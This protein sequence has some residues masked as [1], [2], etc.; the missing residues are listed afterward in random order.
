M[1]DGDSPKQYVK[2]EQTR[3]HILAVAKREFLEKG[4]LGASI[5]SIAKLSEVTTG[6]IFRYFPD[7]ESLFGALVSPVADTVLSMY[8][9]GGQQGCQLLESGEPQKMWRIS[10]QFVH[11]FVEYLFG[12][13]EAFALLVNC[14]GGSSYERFMDRL[15]AEAEEQTYS[16]LQEMLRKGYPCKDLSREEIHILISAQYYAIFEIVRH[17]LSKEDA[18]ARLRLIGD[19][20]RPGWNGIF[21]DGQ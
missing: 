20:F 11:D 18:A 2:G 16:F 3:Q 19:F 6:A 5:R 7:K 1:G 21:G 12:N 15:V 13:K 4:Y 14:S 9:A 10:D 8:S 17:D